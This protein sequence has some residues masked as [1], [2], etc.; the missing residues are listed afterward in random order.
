MLSFV[1]GF[2]HWGIVLARAAMLLFAVLWSHIYVDANNF[3]EVAQSTVL[4][5]C[6][7]FLVVCIFVIDFV[8]ATE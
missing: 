2:S 1:N 3:H 5:F 4:V 8:S 6:L 7:V